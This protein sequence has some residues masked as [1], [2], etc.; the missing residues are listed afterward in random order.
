MTEQGPGL[1]PSQ[2]VGP[3]LHLVL[4]DP[5]AAE[6]VAVG[7][8]GA[9]VIGG[10]VLDGAGDPVPDAVVETWQAGPEGEAD[11]VVQHPAASPFAPSWFGRCPTDAD[12]RWTVRTA[13]PGR[14][15]TY[16]DQT[17]APYVWVSVFAR[18]LLDR[19]VT[20][21]YFADE[22]D[23]NATDPVLTNVPLERRAR[24][25]AAVAPDGYRLDIV[26]QGDD[27]TPFF[28]V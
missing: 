5:A 16:A 15:A 24:L 25:I 22:P 27:E 18:G 17:Q 19:V 6:V 7:A 20:R 2:T 12:G 4:A 10:R 3:F 28:S 23:A 21:L 26:L 9:V 14:L 1:T 8:P 13:K 11:E